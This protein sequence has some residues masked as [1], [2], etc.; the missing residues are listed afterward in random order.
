MTLASL[1]RGRVAA[2][3]V[4]CGADVA[5]TREALARLC[6]AAC[7]GDLDY[8]IVDST[9]LGAVEINERLAA[10]TIVALG[11]IDLD[12]VEEFVRFTQWWCESGGHADEH[13]LGR[14]TA[15]RFGF[16][17]TRRDFAAA[18]VE[19]YIAEQADA[20]EWLLGFID[21]DTVAVSLCADL[22]I[23]LDHAGGV[24]VM[25]RHAAHKYV[26][27]HRSRSTVDLS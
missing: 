18:Y 10:E 9:G 15:A 21:Y 7:V 14:F 8:T 22:Y 6:A 16:H 3:W 13:T 2:R 17:E 5:T 25:E 24:L 12:H 1:A 27:E 4:D 23:A 19:E 20:A 26:P 11:E